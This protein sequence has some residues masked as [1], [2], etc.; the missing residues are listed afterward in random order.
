MKRIFKY[1][2]WWVGREVNRVLDAVLEQRET[3]RQDRGRIG[4]LRAA[5]WAIENSLD[6]AE[7]RQA[8]H[9]ALEADDDANGVTP[10]DAMPIQRHTHAKDNE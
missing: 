10:S 1:P 4:K 7:L 9:D 2:L 8:A 5:L 3:V 6:D